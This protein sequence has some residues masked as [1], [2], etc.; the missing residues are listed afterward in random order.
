MLATL[1]RAVLHV[2]TLDVAHERKEEL[3]DLALQNHGGGGTSEKGFSQWVRCRCGLEGAV[4]EHDLE[5]SAC[6]LGRKPRVVQAVGPELSCACL[7]L[8]L[9]LP[10][11]SWRLLGLSSE[12]A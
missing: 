2:L 10:E 9:C 1:T 7:N 5:S 12:T 6:M 11:P 8:W 3:G 4:C